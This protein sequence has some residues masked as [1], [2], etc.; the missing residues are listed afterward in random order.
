VNLDNVSRDDWI[1]GGLALLLV[2]VLL[3]F[4]WFSASLGPFTVSSTATGSP[5]G[6]LG[7]L[8]VL[9]SLAVVADLGI[10]RLSPQTT[11]PAIGGDRETTRLA[12][13]VAAAAFVALKFVFHIHFSGL[14]SFDWGFYLA[15]IVAGGLVYFAMQARSVATVATPAG[16]GVPAAPAEGAGPAAPG[17][18]PPPPQAPQPAAP[19]GPP[20][21][22]QAPEPAA[23]PPAEAAGPAPPPPA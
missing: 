21:A 13:A 17:G 1:L 14:V 15:V 10:E 19:S 7:V 22:A 11:L 16:P 8:G 23:P 20:P 3:F 2:I 12:L 9:A 4:P 5:D 18:P 6:W